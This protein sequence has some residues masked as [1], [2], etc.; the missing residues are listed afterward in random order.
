MASSTKPVSDAGMRWG[1]AQQGGQ[2]QGHQALRRTLWVK[3]E[4]TVK[5]CNRMGTVAICCIKDDEHGVG[6]GHEG[7]GLRRFYRFDHSLA[8]VVARMQ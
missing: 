2:A 3:E 6:L 5:H 8:K 7:K 1:W 4:V